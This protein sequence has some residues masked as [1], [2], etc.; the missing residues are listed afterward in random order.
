MSA[1]RNSRVVV[2]MSGGVDSSVAALLLLRQGYE[3]HGVFMK[4]WEDSVDT[5][6]CSVAEDLSDAEDVCETLGIP[7][8]KVNFSEQYRQ[9]VFAHFLAEHQAGRTPNPDI[10]CNKEIKFRAFLDHARQ[11]GAEHIAT[12]HYARLC[13][14]GSSHLLKGLDPGKDQSYFLHALNQEQIRDALFP[15]GELHKAEVRE[16]AADNDLITYN[17][18]D[19]TG[20]C[21]IGERDFR[22]FL[23]QYLANQP[24]PM[25]TPEGEIV[26]Q[27]IGLSFYTIGQRH[28]LGIGGRASTPAA[29]NAGSSTGGE[30][31]YVVDKNTADN[32]LIV[33]QGG[34]HPLLFSR[35]LRASQLHW[36]AQ[37][38]SAPFRCTAKTRYRQADQACTILWLEDGHCEVEFEQDQRAVTPG[39]SVVFYHG[40]E[41][42]GGGIIDVA[43]RH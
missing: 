29:G 40:Q 18:K 34:N 35:R 11:L 9:R 8:H 37:T 38:P 26:G 10:L 36:I 41:C 39:Q 5:G 19:S 42:L 20:I 14:N 28:G 6:Y 12:G 33:A 15:L 27:H 16:L 43:L 3:V 7:L 1:R 22:A 30:P 32:A 21:F 25:R 24:G 23:Q 31:W 17:K 13:H 2:G 4:N